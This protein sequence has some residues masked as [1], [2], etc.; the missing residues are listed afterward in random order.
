MAQLE[1]FFSSDY[2]W[3]TTHFHCIIIVC[4]FNLVISSNACHYEE[5]FLLLF[6]NDDALHN[7]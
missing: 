3:I 2:L 5:P 7:Q 4:L 1:D 6:F